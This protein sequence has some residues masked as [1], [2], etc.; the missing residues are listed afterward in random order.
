VA[1]WHAAALFV[2]A[3]F[4]EGVTRRPRVP[5]YKTPVFN[6]WRI[7]PA[8]FAGDIVAGEVVTGKA[9]R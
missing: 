2:G 1:I 5:A 7:K 6:A 9:P 4:A 3:A 8:N